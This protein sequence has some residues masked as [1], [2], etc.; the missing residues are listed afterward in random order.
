MVKVQFSS[1]RSYNLLEKLINRKADILFP[2]VFF[3][4]DTIFLWQIFI[5]FSRNH[6]F[7][8]FPFKIISVLIKTH[9]KFE[10]ALKN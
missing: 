10:K 4:A 2:M 5:F 8:R 7:R 6:F 1:K 9:R 3:I